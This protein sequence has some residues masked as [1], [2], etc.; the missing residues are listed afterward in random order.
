VDDPLPLSDWLRSDAADPAN[1][2]V[3]WERETSWNLRDHLARNEPSAQAT[4][5]VGP[6][7]GFDP[8]EIEFASAAGFV[9]VSLGHA[10]LRAETAGVA[11][12]TI[13]QYAWGSLGG[14]QP[15]LDRAPLA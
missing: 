12:L 15:T 14:P 11:A 6:E 2:L 9:P 4:L 7:G 10:I 8:E 1:R 3:L 13:L 5:L